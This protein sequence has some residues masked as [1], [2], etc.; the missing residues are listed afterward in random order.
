MCGLPDALSVIL[1]VPVR[2]PAA[3]GVNVT[4]MVQ[5][6][7]AVT[8]LPQLSVSLKS[9]LAAMLVMLK[10]ALPEFVSVAGWAALVLPTVTVLNVRLEG[11][12]LTTGAGGGGL[13]PPPPQ[14]T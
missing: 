5:F 6:A 3:V 11:E 13:L 10:V 9:P 4:F 14:A 12:R 7:P 8:E 2:D 1:R